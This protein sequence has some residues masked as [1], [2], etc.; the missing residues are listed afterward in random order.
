MNGPLY[1]QNIGDQYGF[2][3]VSAS[4]YTKAKRKQQQLLAMKQYKP[5][6]LSLAV[7]TN[8]IGGMAV[9][10]VFSLVSIDCSN[11]CDRFSD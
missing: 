7:T 10:L 8:G 3:L 5:C 2:A 9:Q 4:E 1:I 11:T 6:D